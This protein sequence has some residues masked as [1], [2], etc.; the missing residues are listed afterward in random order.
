[1]TGCAPRTDVWEAKI[2]NMRRECEDSR[3]GMA[4]IDHPGW[5]WW[6]CR[7]GQYHRTEGDGFDLL[8]AD[9]GEQ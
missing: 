2:A 9:Q 4:L 6:L 8:T 3:K 1:M 5:R 7:C